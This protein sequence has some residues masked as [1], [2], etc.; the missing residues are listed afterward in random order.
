MFSNYLDKG[1]WALVE[2]LGLHGPLV[3]NQEPSIF[4]KF[5]AAFDIWEIL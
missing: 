4:I 3:T 1:F 2:V 5:L